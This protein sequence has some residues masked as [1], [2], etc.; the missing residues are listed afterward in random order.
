MTR[1][2][3]KRFDDQTAARINLATMKMIREDEKKFG[4]KIVIGRNKPGPKKEKS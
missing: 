4:K 2:L 3:M 1:A